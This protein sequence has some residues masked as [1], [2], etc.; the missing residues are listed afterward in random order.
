MNLY[1]LEKLVRIVVNDFYVSNWYYYQKKK[2]FLGITINK[3]GVYSCLWNQ[4][5]GTKIPKNLV[6]KNGILYEKPEVILRY[7]SNIE[8]TYIFDTLKE[9]NEFRD[10]VKELSGANFIS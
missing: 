3:E 5:Q 4:F 1:N 8:K 6:L 10:K 2:T 7:E 9:A